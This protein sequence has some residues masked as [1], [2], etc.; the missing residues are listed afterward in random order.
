MR[1]EYSKPLY[2]C[3]LV[4][5]SLVLMQIGDVTALYAPFFEFA[6]TNK[7]F[8]VTGRELQI[9]KQKNHEW[10]ADADKIGFL[11]LFPEGDFSPKIGVY[12]E[13]F[14]KTMRLRGE[15]GGYPAGNF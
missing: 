13:D 1:I 7:D 4:L 12:L 8:K 15:K 14:I 5:L 10:V 2:P 3:L 9:A 11:N 6:D